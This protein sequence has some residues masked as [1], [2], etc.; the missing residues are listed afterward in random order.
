MIKTEQ[1]FEVLLRVERDRLLSTPNPYDNYSQN[2]EWQN[3]QIPPP[4]Q[5][6]IPPTQYQQPAYQPAPQYQQPG[7]YPPQQY[8]QPGYY[9]PPGVYAPFGMPVAPPD[10]RGG[11]AIAGLVLGI[12]GIVLAIVPICGLPIPIVGIVMSA[13]GRKSVLHRTMAGWG[14]ALSI[15]S[16]VLTVLISIAWVAR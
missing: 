2:P 1:F 13:L 6:A 12:V 9:Q 4:S 11:F 3:D 14:L 16:L 8:Q 15:I 7:Y 10:R 5:P